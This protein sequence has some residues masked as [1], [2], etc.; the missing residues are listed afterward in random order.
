MGHVPPAAAWRGTRVTVGTANQRLR[1]LE[2]IETPHK[3]THRVA[4]QS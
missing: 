4:R 2:S 1:R 3:E